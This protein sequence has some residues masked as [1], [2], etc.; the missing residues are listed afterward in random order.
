MINAAIVPS[1]S[2]TTVAGDSTTVKSQLTIVVHTK[3]TK[4]MGVLLFAQ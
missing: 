2:L 4:E 1:G 3:R